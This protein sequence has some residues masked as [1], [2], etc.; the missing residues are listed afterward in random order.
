MKKKIPYIAALIIFIVALIA[1]VYSV[2]R[3]VTYEKTSCTIVDIERYTDGTIIQLQYTVNDTMY[4]RESRY[5]KG[6]SIKIG[7]ELTLWYDPD[8]PSKTV[9]VRDFAGFYYLLAIM[10]G[11]LFLIPSIGY[12]IGFIDRIQKSVKINNSIS[13]DILS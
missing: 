5:G 1:T 9:R 8:D 10:G 13:L 12:L 4:E 11:G 2:F 3:F 6:K 7:E